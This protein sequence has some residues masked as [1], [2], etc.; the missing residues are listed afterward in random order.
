[1]SDEKYHE[2]IALD[3]LPA[4]WEIEAVLKPD[5]TAY[6]WLPRLTDTTMVEA[7]DDRFVAAFDIGWRYERRRKKGEPVVYPKFTLA[8]VVRAVTPG[9]FIM[10]AVRVE[11]MYKPSV[12]A[13]TEPSSLTVTAR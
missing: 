10:P 12:F 3:L 6:E 5:D 4:G 11:D 9:D 13:R 2:M 8:Y 1:M 7:R